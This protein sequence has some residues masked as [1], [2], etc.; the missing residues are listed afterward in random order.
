LSDAR[1]RLGRLLAIRKSSADLDRR[2]LQDALGSVAQ[3][4]GALERQE[5]ARMQ[6]RAEAQAALHTGDRHEWLLAEAQHEIAGMN[7]TGLTQLLAARAEKVPQAMQ[8]FVEGRRA[9]EQVQQLVEN[10]R[11][12]EEVEAGRRTQSASDDWY[13]SKWVRDA[14]RR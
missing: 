6:A 3:V 12:V 9:H 5:T 4:E 2:A 13:L 1:H 7:R 10:A 11:R 14:A 8:R